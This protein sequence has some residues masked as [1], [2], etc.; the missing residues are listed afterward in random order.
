L[1]DGCFAGFVEASLYA[2]PTLF[3]YWNALCNLVAVW[4]PLWHHCVTKMPEPAATWFLA[5]YGALLASVTFVWNLVRDLRDRADVRLT[6]MLG[7]MVPNPQKKTYLILTITNVGRRP[8]FV[9]GWG[10][11]YKNTSDRG[12]AGQAFVIMTQH[13]P[14]MLNE[15]EYVIEMAENYESALA[16]DV[17]AIAVWDSSDRKWYLSKKQMRGLRKQLTEKKAKEKV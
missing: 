1:R 16:E 10:G 3:P 4:T 2:A 9:T 8:V 13:I 12:R 14:K 11:W 17:K 15:G 7:H 5:L 6:A